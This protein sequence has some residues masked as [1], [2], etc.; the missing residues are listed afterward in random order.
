MP[1]FTLLTVR[2]APEITYKVAR[3]MLSVDGGEL[4]DPRFV[5]Y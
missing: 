4:Y 2:Y 3:G 5:P 1:D